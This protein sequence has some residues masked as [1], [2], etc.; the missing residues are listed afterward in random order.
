MVSSHKFLYSSNLFSAA[1]TAVVD[2]AYFYDVVNLIR[3]G[4]TLRL[5]VMIKLHLGCRD[6]KFFRV[7]TVEY[8]LSL[9]H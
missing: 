7:S 6:W 2:V 4:A 8:S 9:D 5:T 3:F 1:R